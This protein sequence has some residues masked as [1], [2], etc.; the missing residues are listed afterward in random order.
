MGSATRLPWLLLL[1]Y[2][3]HR[4]STTMDTL[5]GLS[6]ELF[7]REKHS[8]GPIPWISVAWTRCHSLTPTSLSHKYAT[9][10]VQPPCQTCASLSLQ[11]FP[12]GGA[13][14]Y[15]SP[16]P[17]SS[18]HYLELLLR[19][20][21]APHHRALTAIGPWRTCVRGLYLFQLSAKS[22]LSSWFFPT[23]TALPTTAVILRDFPSGKRRTLPATPF[24]G[25]C[26]RPLWFLSLP[27]FPSCPVLH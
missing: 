3:L 20:R 25:D 10:V 16:S 21:V 19:S 14:G 13:M 12:A 2:V 1:S 15:W 7:P 24:S 5:S 27:A 8:T 26:Q 4:L 18:R 23:R 22:F 17:R 9:N 6:P 11:I